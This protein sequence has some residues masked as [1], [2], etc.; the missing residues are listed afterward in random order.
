MRN[1]IIAIVIILLV[2]MIAGLSVGIVTAY[3]SSSSL[4]SVVSGGGAFISVTTIGI[5]MAAWLFPPSQG[6]GPTSP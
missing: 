6:Q 2:G 4:T 3:L 1:R 5:A